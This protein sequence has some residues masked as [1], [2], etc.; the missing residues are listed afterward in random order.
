[1]RLIQRPDS[2]ARK[3]VS[4]CAIALT[5]AF[6]KVAFAADLPTGERTLGQ[7][8][9]EPAYDDITG[10][11]IYLLTPKAPEKANQH[12]VAP[13]YLIL[14][15]TSA[16][17]SVGTLNCQHQPMDNCPDHGPLVA[18]LAEFANPTVYG[19]GVWGHDH[20][21]A[22]PPSPPAAGDFNVA[23]EPIAVIFNDSASANTHITTLAQLNA[24]I[25]GGLVT[26]IP[27]PT[28]TFHCSAVPATIYNNGTPVTPVP[29][30]P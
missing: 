30:L 28:A 29:G 22:A 1:M 19:A 8:V 9:I 16:S 2:V 18:G 21:V 25:Q 23:W 17:S 26:L 15:P 4:V 20:L 14:Y 24:A 12:A 27:L 11:F 7:S 6:S 13:L 5:F 10:K 3:V